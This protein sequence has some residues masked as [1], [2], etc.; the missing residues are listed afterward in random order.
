MLSFVL[1]IF[2]THLRRA[3]KFTKVNTKQYIVTKQ[4]NKSKHVQT[5]VAG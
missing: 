3:E 5:L 2:Q 4:N 1:F